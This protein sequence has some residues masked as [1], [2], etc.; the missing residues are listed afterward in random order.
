MSK[1]SPITNARP[2]RSWSL[3]LLWGLVLG[4]W[5]LTSMTLDLTSL[6]QSILV[7][8]FK[9]GGDV[10]KNVS[11]IRPVSLA[12]ETGE[13]AVNE[14]SVATQAVIGV[15]LPGFAA[16]R[17][18]DHERLLIRATDINT[19]TAPAAGDYIVQASSGVPARCYISVARSHRTSLEL[20][21]RPIPAPGLRR[22]HR[23]RHQRRLE[24][25]D[26]GDR[27]RRSRSAL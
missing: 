10:V 26:G 9:L 23:A 19:I 6:T 15:A 22:S 11:Y 2:R 5:N 27:C 20:S 24:R 7:T 8:V 4:P 17:S 25:P 14:I 21:H 1:E 18:S 13:S 3:E 12:K 16:S